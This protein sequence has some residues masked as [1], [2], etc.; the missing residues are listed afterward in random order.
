MISLQKFFNFKKDKKGTKRFS[1]KNYYI[2]FFLFQRSSFNS[3]KKND[4]TKLRY[5]TQK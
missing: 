4:I 5:L 2:K 1:K 3:L